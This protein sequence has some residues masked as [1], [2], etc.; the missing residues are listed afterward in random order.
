MVVVSDHDEDLVPDEPPVLVVETT[1][2]SDSSCRSS[3]KLGGSNIVPDRMVSMDVV[4]GKHTAGLASSILN[5][6]KNI[7]GASMLSMSY[8]VSC[9]GVVPS[10]I[11]CIG[12]GLL[13]AYTFG[14]IGIMCGQARVR[15]FRQLCEKY[16]HPKAGI[17]MDLFLA[18][19]AFPACLAYQ[20]FI[21][22]VLTK[23]ISELASS[24]DVFYAS[25]WFVGITSAM[26]IL[27]PLCMIDK[28]QSLTYTSLI[29]IGA[30]IYTYIFVAV[31]LANVNKSGQVSS[32]DILASAIWWPPSGSVLGLFTIA[33]IWAACYVVHYNAP[34]FFY[35]LSRPTNKRMYILSLSA[36]TVV[37]LFCGSFAILGFARF[38]MNT[39]DDLLIG[40]SGAY[41]VWV[42]ICVSLVTTYPFVFDAGRRSL[43]SAFSHRMSSRKIWWI[44]TLVIIPTFTVVAIFLKS[45]GL[46]IGINGSI[47]G[48]TFGLTLPGA[49][50]YYKTKT[51]L[52]TN[53][54]SRKNIYIG[55]ALVLGG[56]LMAVIGMV[57][58][59]VDLGHSR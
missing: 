24:P 19:Y 37:M 46:V 4:S 13:F 8:G 38:G 54:E 34:Q 56:I 29:G 36:N 48:M 42:A 44:S 11:L 25:R 5:L 52:N 43:I 23:M 41:A 33:N 31:D 16:F 3:I 26:L 1:R 18:L 10:V 47:C 2:E 14:I 9:A 58:L 12:F 55:I 53:P 6:F 40:Y 32:T 35:E 30:I 39:Q 49:L 7:V 21:N 17:Y 45:L 22:S 20:I 28:I 57:S 15:G 27:L 59:F 51:T 50:L